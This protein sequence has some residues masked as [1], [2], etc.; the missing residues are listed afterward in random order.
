MAQSE[1]EPKASRPNMPSYGL[2]DAES[3]LLPWSWATERLT[4]SHNYYL[5]TT[6]PDNHP[7]VMPI[8]G[9]WMDNLFYFSTG[10]KSRKARNLQSNPHCVLCTEKLEESLIVEGIAEQVPVTFIPAPVAE[11][12][13]TK[14]AWKLD[15]E[16]GPIY[17]IRPTVVFGFDENDFTGSSTRWTFDNN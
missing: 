10:Q 1:K 7:H 16:M 5:A 11:A 13:Q 3:G 2:A 4:D 17:K 14:Y 12:Y 6:R 9:V 15:P 8:W